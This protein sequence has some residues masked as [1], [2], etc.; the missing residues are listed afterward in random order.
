M[1]AARKLPLL[2]IV[3]ATGT[4]KSKLAIELAQRFNGEIISA[5]S[6]QVYRGLDIITN[7]V[8]AEELHCCRHHLIGY[9]DP[10]TPNNSVVNF[11]NQALPIIDKLFDEDK[12]PVI[13][14]GTNY[15]I[16]ALLWNFLINNKDI[17]RAKKEELQTVGDDHVTLLPETE[18]MEH[19]ATRTKGSGEDTDKCK[20]DSMLRCHNSA[21]SVCENHE[22]SGQSN[23]KVLEGRFAALET[24][25]LYRRLMQV[26]PDK[27]RMVHPHNRR[28][29]IRSLE[30]YE[31]HGVAISDIH[32][33]QHLDRGG[34]ALSGPLRYPNACILW[35]QCEHKVLCERLDSRVNYMVERGLLQ[36]L[37]NFHTYYKQQTASRSQKPDYTLG[38]FQSIGFKEFH[39]YLMLTDDEKQSEKGRQ[40]KEE[41]I[42][43]LKLVTRRYAKRQIQW[44]K[45]RFL[46]RPG[47]NVPLI[48]SVDST[49][50]SRW[51]D[52][53]HGPAE[54]IVT[55][56]I[57]G[58][59]ASVAPVQCS[60]ELSDE[61]VYNV[62]HV[63]G[64]RVF[65]TRTQWEGHIKSR[66]HKKLFGKKLKTEREEQQQTDKHSDR[67]EAEEI[68]H[69]DYCQMKDH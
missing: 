63:C 46:R 30:V 14:G 22:Y 21:P 5:D 54:E 52:D 43:E 48:Y 17:K 65:V 4:G 12:M 20:D 62:C 57:E 45:N 15:Y 9:V 1:A 34:P 8:T 2:V 28:R 66:R 33:A 56:I 23:S 60:R 38:I 69:D 49:E 6:M 13:V 16:E 40:L 37:D 61:P 47:E 51:Q 58:R 50:T 25:D 64:G 67:C 27:G 59:P 44:I 24:N 26:D 29:I 31:D 7:K 53:V 32:R 3:G 55:A 68:N 35:I 41:G 18:P 36:E 10:F 39:N 42:A 11:K 19:L